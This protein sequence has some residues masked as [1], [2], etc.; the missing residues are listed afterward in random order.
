MFRTNLTRTHQ[1]VEGFLTALAVSLYEVGL[2]H[3]QNGMML[4][5]FTAERIRTCLGWL[6]RQN[7][8]GC[9]IYIRPAHSLGVVMLDDL[10]TMAVSRLRSD[11]L[12]PCAVVETSHGNFQVWIRLIHNRGKRCLDPRLIR[13]SLVAFA[14]QYGADHNAAD[15]RHFGR[16]PG[17][18]NRKPS[19]SLAGRPPF[20]LLRF[21]GSIVAAQ[22][23]KQLIAAQRR[24]DTR[25]LPSGPVSPSQGFFKTMAYHDRR[26]RILTINRTQPW[27]LHPDPSR[28][29]FMIAREMLNEGY[30]IA[31][32]GKTIRDS[33]DL[34]ARK[35]G[36]IDDYIVRTIDAVLR[37]STLSPA[38]PS[39]HP[40]STL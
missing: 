21:A 23:R 19:R 39:A 7:A 28:L 12:D 20:V 6:R 26:H 34:Q 32:V 18:T 31:F 13:E 4:R 14:A 38:L 24:L 29:D 35:S 22:G 33:P 11:G 10:D 1:A 16:L 2:R 8:L 17:F 15:W 36:H 40:H 25:E 3:P 30:S 37:T 27:A 9:D 5:T